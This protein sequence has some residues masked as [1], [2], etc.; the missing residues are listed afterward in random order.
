M[1]AAPFWTTKTLSEMNEEEWESLC[2]RC[3]KCCVLKVEDVDT[4]DI[5]SLIHI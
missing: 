3:G 5:L 4:G 2:D 1:D